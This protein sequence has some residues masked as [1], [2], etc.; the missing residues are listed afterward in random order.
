MVKFL[1][2]ILTAICLF[3]FI[4]SQKTLANDENKKYV[5]FTFDDG[6]TAKNTPMMLDKLKE[7]NI[8]ATFF[9]VGKLINE[10]PQVL[11]RIRDENHAIGLHTMSHNRNKCYAS[12]ETFIKENS[13]LRDL[14]KS[15]FNID[16]NL[17][18]FPFGSQ[19]SY[20]KMDKIFLE[21]LHNNGFK[22]YDWHIDTLDALKPQN[23]AETILSICK[24]Q[25]QKRFSENKNLVVLMHTNSNNNYTIEA[26]PLLKDY[27]SSLGYE[28]NTLTNA[29]ELY[30][31][32]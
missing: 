10:N 19:N 30:N 22:I 13:E 32:K 17:I 26:L 12:H 28:F 31:I 9:V 15:K 24:S 1:S 20:L 23:T 2:K 16:A 18:R 11:E 4:G 29:P 21:K 3:T 25:F 5:Y 8:P 6:P 14:L 7:L 27:F